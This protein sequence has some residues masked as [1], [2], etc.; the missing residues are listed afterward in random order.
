[1]GDG[2]E[3]G[4]D[5]NSDEALAGLHP[6]AEPEDGPPLAQIKASPD[7]QLNTTPTKSDLLR[8]GLDSTVGPTN[9]KITITTEPP[10]DTRAPVLMTNN[11]DDLT[12]NK[13]GPPTLRVNAQGYYKGAMQTI[14]GSLPDEP[15]RKD[16]TI[17]DF[18]RLVKSG[19]SAYEAGK[20][21]AKSGNDVDAAVDALST[22]SLDGPQAEACLSKGNCF[23]TQIPP[24]TKD[25]KA[26]ADK[27]PKS[28]PPPP[29]MAPM[30]APTLPKMPHQKPKEPPITISYHDAQ[31]MHPVDYPEVNQ[32]ITGPMQSRDELAAQSKKFYY[33]GQKGRGN[34]GGIGGLGI[35]HLT[36]KPFQKINSEH[37]DSGYDTLDGFARDGAS[38]VYVSRTGSNNG[39][40]WKKPNPNAYGSAVVTRL[41][42]HILQ[43][44][45]QRAAPPTKRT[46]SPIPA[47]PLP[48]PAAAKLPPGFAPLD[49]FGRPIAAP[50]A[51]SKPV[52]GPFDD[53]DAVRARTPTNSR[54]A[55]F[56]FASPFPAVML[57]LDEEMMSDR[58][59]DENPMLL[60]TASVL[61]DIDNAIIYDEQHPNHSSNTII[62]VEIPL[63]DNI[64]PSAT[65]LAELQSSFLS[66]KSKFS[67]VH[68]RT[69][70]NIA[71]SLLSISA[72]SSASV[73]GRVT[74]GTDIAKRKDSP[75][76]VEMK[77]RYNAIMKPWTL[78]PKPLPR[79]KPPPRLSIAD[80]LR[81]V[82]RLAA[83]RAAQIDAK[84]KADQAKGASP[85]LPVDVWPEIVPV[86]NHMIH[87][88]K[89]TKGGVGGWYKSMRGLLRSK[90][91]CPNN[92]PKFGDTAGRP[93]QVVCNCTPEQL[94][95]AI[96]RST[97]DNL[98]P[99]I[100]GIKAAKEPQMVGPPPLDAVDTATDYFVMPPKYPTIKVNQAPKLA[101][102]LIDP[103]RPAKK[104]ESEKKK[105]EQEKPKPAGY[106][107]FGSP[108]IGSVLHPVDGPEDGNPD[109]SS[110]YDN[111]LSTYTAKQLKDGS[112]E[113]KED[114][115][116]DKKEEGGDDAA[117]SE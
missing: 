18:N 29:K 76:T 6:L 110:I 106:S 78:R 47:R 22:K 11:P 45:Y 105:D 50:K 115:G 17:D 36:G 54:P 15:Q 14:M 109:A 35:N 34:K 21:L 80:T 102:K 25:A 113:K 39:G 4:I 57:Q 116:D 104:T 42:P 82:Q 16:K 27:G 23:N 64:M 44:S 99:A 60:A 37:W 86:K 71:M 1:M 65:E 67:R 49:P 7:D 83:M 92:L 61:A 75:R 9:K 58:E 8:A 74:D 84:K 77:R 114:G 96:G 98:L 100:P 5:R 38:T 56:G 32:Y 10:V 111:E 101:R 85:Q 68:D 81:N 51:A 31:N 62:Q 63:D 93:E 28:T 88:K 55:G 112:D 48:P 91:K 41:S 3:E 73:A 70:N 33:Y 69:N 108:Y 43:R 72:S 52:M 26:K 19:F 97:D 20:A 13:L 87:L 40:A 66:A 89:I 103:L 53:P 107:T 30:P 117:T 24:A 2:P 59:L 12:D 46:R 79:A 95:E 94:R 90:C